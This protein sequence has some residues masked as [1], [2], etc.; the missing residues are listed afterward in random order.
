MK[1]IAIKTE[2]ISQIVH[3]CYV[4]LS[5][6]RNLNF[7]FPNGNGTAHLLGMYLHVF[8]LIYLNESFMA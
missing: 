3:V 8:S 5:I 2:A 7:I 1:K 4:W 6:Y